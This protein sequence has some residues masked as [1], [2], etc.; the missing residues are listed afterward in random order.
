[1]RRTVKLEHQ[2]LDQTGGDLL[3]MY[4]EMWGGRGPSAP[5]AGAASSNRSRYRRVE[6]GDGIEVP[7]DHLGPMVRGTRRQ[8]ARDARPHSRPVR[9]SV[10]TSLPQVI[11][12]LRPLK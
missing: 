12:T 6:G 1:M 3:Q 11:P 4:I 8:L 9:V 7:L 5:G 10:T 2:R